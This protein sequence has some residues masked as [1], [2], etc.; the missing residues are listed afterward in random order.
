MKLMLRTTKFPYVFW[1]FNRA[2]E[3]ELSFEKNTYTNLEMKTAYTFKA[4]NF[5]LFL[6]LKYFPIFIIFYFTFSIWDFYFSKSTISAYIL[7]LFLS[8][9]VN[10]L[11]HTARKIGVGILIVLTLFLSYFIQDVFLIA[12]VFKYFIL[13]SVGIILYLDLHLRVYC[14]LQNNKVVSHFLVPKALLKKL[15]EKQ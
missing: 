7:A 12:Y 4:F 9:I 10:I 13:F 2:Y 15:K 14:L 3:C 1:A 8:C 6:I 5:Y 11:E